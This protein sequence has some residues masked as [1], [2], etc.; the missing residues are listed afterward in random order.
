MRQISYDNSPT[1]YIVPTPIGN[2]EDIT[3]RSINVL[4]NVDVIFCEDTRVT[5]QLLMHYNIQKKLVSNHKYNEHE[6][7]EKILAELKSNHNI[8]VVSDRGMPGIS[9]PGYIGAEYAIANN[10]NVVCLPGACAFLPAL[11]MSGICPQ[12]FLFYGFLNSKTAKRKEELQK[13]KG[14]EETVIIYEAPHRLKTTLEDILEIYGNINI[15]VSREISKLHEE[16]I[17]DTVSNIIEISD[18]LKGEFVIIL[19]KVIEKIDYQNI[20]VK[21]QVDSFIEQGMDK[22]EAIKKVAKTRN[23]SKSDVYNEYHRK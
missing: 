13:L 1:L 6:I 18:T 12:P 15:V 3:L 19:P 14:K 17:R 2:M 20:D 8:A 11:M 5:K 10:F 16:V 9:D 23:V 22:K 4:K 7:K 21:T